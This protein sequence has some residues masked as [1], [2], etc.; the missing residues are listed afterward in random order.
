MLQSLTQLNIQLHFA[1]VPV[2]KEFKETFYQ[3][4]K[5]KAQLGLKQESKQIRRRKVWK[6]KKKPKKTF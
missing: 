3:R 5:K 6:N 1:E 4:E 2:P